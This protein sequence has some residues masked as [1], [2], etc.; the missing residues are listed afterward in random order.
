MVT[1]YLEPWQ[2]AL[3]GQAAERSR[4]R[5]CCGLLLG[6]RWGGAD[7]SGDNR[8]VRVRAVEPMEN[9]WDQGGAAVLDGHQPVGDQGDGVLTFGDRSPGESSSAAHGSADR[10]AI[11]PAQMLAAARAARDRGWAIVG[12]YHSHPNGVAVPSEC[13]RQWAWEEY[14]YAIVAVTDGR[15]TDL[16]FWQLDEQRRFQPLMVKGDGAL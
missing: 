1:V 11:D 5:E 14:V 4:D 12:I 2:V 8:V 9:I 10:Y 16:K 15:A 7:P 3:M 6:T 13:D